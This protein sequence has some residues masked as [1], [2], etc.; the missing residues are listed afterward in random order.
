MGNIQEETGNKKY[1][2]N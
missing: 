2:A 1:K